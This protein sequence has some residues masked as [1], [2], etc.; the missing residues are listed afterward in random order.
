MSLPAPERLLVRLPNPLGDTIMCTPA[1]R[2]LRRHWPAAR[3]TAAGTLAGT[4]VLSGLASVDELLPLP[5][6]RSAG[7]LSL[8]ATARELRA[9]RFDLAILCT[10]SFSSALA[11][12][13][14]GVPRRVG[15]AG[16]GRGPLL[17]LRCHA[18]SERGR[19]RRPE[20]M[21]EFYGR[22]LDALAV[23]R[24]GHRTELAVP[25]ADAARATAWLA[26]QGLPPEAGLVGLHGGAAFGPSKL[27]YPE[28][29]AAVADA[30]HQRHGLRALLFGG[31]GEASLTAAI[32]AA[33]KS[34]VIDAARPEV[35]VP[36]LKALV[37]RL[38]LLV[39]TD[40]GPRHLAPPFDVPVVTLLGPTDPRHSNTNLHGTLVLRSG[41]AC[42]PCQL[43]ECPLPEPEHHACMRRLE[44]AEVLAA[45][46]RQLAS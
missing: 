23:P 5:S 36:L 26:A 10:N 21:P 3:I 13:L 15:Y 16:G 32:A 30:L 44:V 39:C 18:A 22:L 27:W 45:C 37:A 25:A 4:Q 31:P 41:V 38:R 46:E 43:K 12:A 17:T 2:A 33:S 24:D 20:P 34:P 35:D 42:S 19:H 11:V 9:R 28:R 14:A 8:L 7:S 29:W 6:R 40:A 1:L